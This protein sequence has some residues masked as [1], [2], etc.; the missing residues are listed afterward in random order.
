MGDASRNTATFAVSRE[1]RVGQGRSGRLNRTGTRR[2]SRAGRRRAGYGT[3]ERAR[4]VSLQGGPTFAKK[5][6]AG[7][8]YCTNPGRA[9]DWRHGVPVRATVYPQRKRIFF[10]VRC[11]HQIRLFHIPKTVDCF[12]RYSRKSRLLIMGCLSTSQGSCSAMDHR[13]TR[14]FLSVAALR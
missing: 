12:L 14:S 11:S 10:F 5:D 2:W 1:H 13:P 4:R 3:A 7:R 8:R 6:N 9:F